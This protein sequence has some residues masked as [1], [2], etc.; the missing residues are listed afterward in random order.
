MKLAN[1]AT[2][3][4][5]RTGKGQM[6]SM[7]YLV[8]VVIF[9][10]VLLI[11]LP[12]W[13]TVNQQIAD[14]ESR[15]QLQVISISVAELFLRS[16]GNPMNWTNESVSSIGLANE[17]HIINATKVL[18]LR[19]VNY[20]AAKALLGLNPY[21]FTLN[22]TNSRGYLITSGVARSPA[23]YYGASSRDLLPAISDTGLVW[24]Y[25][26]GHDMPEAEPSHGDARNFYSD[27]EADAL[28]AMIFNATAHHAYSTLIIEQPSVSLAD[29]NL[30]GLAEFVENGGRLIFEG[31]GFGGGIMI[32][33]LGAT[34]EPIMPANGILVN[35][36]LIL[37]SPANGSAVNFAN[38][39]WAFKRGDEGKDLNI[40][41]AE[42]S[43]FSLG[44]I[45]SWDYG[46]GRI[47]YIADAN[48]TAA[49]ENLNLLLNIGGKGLKYGRDFTQ[50]TDI[51]NIE[52]AVLVA[53]DYGDGSQM[54]KMQFIV[55]R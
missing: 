35:K 5:T 31:S 33:G 37:N 32:D 47:Y 15:K 27:V 26:W 1:S 42:Q 44:L 7:D 29:A 40:F 25:Y 23:A 20:D 46:N 8:S 28:N 45:A 49:G 39:V 48:G 6:F 12:T 30:T 54:A 10:L 36:G 38:A 18:G 51:V 19:S 2:A 9:T 34:A 52:R 24:D 13:S 14:A 55:W 50:A 3:N 41:V 53:S 43:N 21:N 17:A 22:F 11:L 16:P 4:A